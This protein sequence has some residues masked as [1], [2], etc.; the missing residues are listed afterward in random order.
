M[1]LAGYYRRF[2]RNFG[3]IAKS[4][5]SLL[6][7]GVLFVWTSSH[8]YS[9]TALK[10]ALVSAPVLSLPNFNLPF[11]LETDA[12]NI[13][14][15][16]VLMQ[17]GHPIAYLSKAL[18]PRNQGL[19]T[20]EKEFL[21]IILAVDHW[22]HYLQLKEFIIHTNHRSLAQLDEQRLHTP[23][24]KKMFTRLLGLQYRIVYKKRIDNGAADVLS[25][26]P[27]L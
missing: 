3:V 4:T 2:V 17:A 18:C 26:N 22:R 27:Q 21:A 12:S 6:K 23:W 5:T 8:E 20:C 9:F 25:R 13:G 19:S 1:G 7:K 11:I 24:Q 10:E 16:A 15:G 14:V